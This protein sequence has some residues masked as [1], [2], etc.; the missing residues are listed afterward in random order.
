MKTLGLSVIGV[1]G[2]P[3][4]IYRIP[5]ENVPLKSEI[6]TKNVK[7]WL[8]E[9]VALLIFLIFLSAVVKFLDAT[10]HLLENVS[11]TITIFIVIRVGLIDNVHI[12]MTNQF[13]RLQ[14][15]KTRCVTLQYLY[16]N[17][18][19]IIIQDKNKFN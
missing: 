4:T 12:G 14:Y 16:T 13:Y 8:I 17:L 6:F 2:G 1:R 9:N 10:D 11:L 3:C 7:E 5:S 18:E 19:I 15:F